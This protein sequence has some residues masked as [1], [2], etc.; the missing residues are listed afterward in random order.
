MFD[1]LVLTAIGVCA[2]TALGLVAYGEHV[3]RYCLRVNEA[4][5]KV[6]EEAKEMVLSVTS[7]GHKINTA[8]QET[9]VEFE[10]MKT[11]LE[12][13]AA[14]FPF[15]WD[16]IAA[17]TFANELATRQRIAAKALGRKT[18]GSDNKSFTKPTVVT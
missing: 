15:H 17:D 4:T 2:V 12:A 13:C 11:A 8:I 6:R 18:L 14:P 10:K 1:D 7:L 9:N 5:T 3:K 16:N